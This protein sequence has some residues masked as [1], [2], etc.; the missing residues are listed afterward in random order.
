[1]NAWRCFFFSRNVTSFLYNIHRHSVIRSLPETLRMNKTVHIWAFKTATG[2]LVFCILLVTEQEQKYIYMII[3]YGYTTETLQKWEPSATQEHA[4]FF[5]IFF[6]FI[7]VIHLKRSFLLSFH[8]FFLSASPL[9]FRWVHLPVPKLELQE[10]HGRGN[11][12]V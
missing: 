7:F 6:N 2:S 3:L 12:F 10:M 8:V 11:I 5:S 4:N 9:I 1:M